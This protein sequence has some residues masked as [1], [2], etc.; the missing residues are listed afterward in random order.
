MQHRR[1]SGVDRASRAEAKGMG[2]ILGWT[3][4]TP[5]QRGLPGDQHEVLGMGST[6]G[7]GDSFRHED[8]EEDNRCPPPGDSIGA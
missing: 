8:E 2:F 5:R 4:R 1:T 6:F 7:K 3:P